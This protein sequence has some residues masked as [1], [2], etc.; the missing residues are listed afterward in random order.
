MPVTSTLKKYYA[1]AT[2]AS[3]SGIFVLSADDAPH[4]LDVEADPSF[5]NHYNPNSPRILQVNGSILSGTMNDVLN[6]IIPDQDPYDPYTYYPYLPPSSNDRDIHYFTSAVNYSGTAYGAGGSHHLGLYDG[7]IFQV[8]LGA[9]GEGIETSFDLYKITLELG[10]F[11]GPSSDPIIVGEDTLEQ[12]Q[13]SPSRPVQGFQT[14][15]GEDVTD[16]MTALLSN[17][18]VIFPSVTLTYDPDND[19][20]DSDNLIYSHYYDAS[21]STSF[22]V[23]QESPTTYALYLESTPGDGTLYIK[24]ENYKDIIFNYLYETMPF[25]SYVADSDDNWWELA[26]LQ[27]NYEIRVETAS[28]A[29]RPLPPIDD[30]PDTFD[31]DTS[32]NYKLLKEIYLYESPYFTSVL[33]EVI[34]GSVGELSGATGTTINGDDVDVFKLSPNADKSYYISIEGSSSDMGSLLNPALLGIYDSYGN[35]LTSSSSGTLVATNSS[36]QL[37]TLAGSTL[38]DGSYHGTS[39]LDEHWVFTPNSWTPH[40]IYVGSEGSNKGTYTFTITLVDKGSINPDNGNNGNGGG[41]TP[42]VANDDVAETTSGTAVV[43][44]VLANDSDADGDTLTILGHTHSNMNEVDI[45]DSDGTITYT[46]ATDFTG[47]VTFSYAID[48]GAEVATANVTVTVTAGEATTPIVDNSESGTDFSSDTQTLGGIVVGSSVT[49]TV[50]PSHDTD[51]YAV[52]L[53]A[54]ITYRIDLEG[55]DTNKGTLSNPTFFGVFDST[56][57]SISGTEDWNGGVGKNAQVDYTPSTSGLY[58]LS[59]GSHLT[60]SYTLSIDTLANIQANNSAPTDIALSSYTITENESGATVGT[61]SATDSDS[62][63]T[64]TFSLLYD[65]SNLFEVVGSTLK[66]KS[67][68]SADNESASSHALTLQVTD[69]VGNSYS[70]TLTIY[71]ADVLEPGQTNTSESSSDF[72][73]NSST[74]GSILSGYSVTGSV[75]QSG[76][77]DWF[78]VQLTAGTQYRIDLA[79]ADS[80]QGTLANPTLYGIYNS[81]SSYQSGSWDGNSGLGFNAQESFTP[82]SSGI[83]YLA[84]GGSELGSYTL[85][86]DT[87]ANIQANNSAPTDIALSSYSVTENESGATVGTLTATDSDTGDTAT[88]SLLYD[89][90]GLFEVVGSTLKLKSGSSADSESA[91]S[92]TL[93]LQVTDSVGSSFNESVT[94]SVDDVAEAG[95]TNSSESSTDFSEN[96]S[97]QGSILVGYAVTGSVGQ[98]GDRDWFAVQLTAGTQYRVDIEGADSSQG[99][100]AN[101]TLYGIYNSASSYQSGSWDG[102]SGLGLNAQESFTPSSSGIYYLAAGGS[103]LGSYTLSVDTMANIQANNSSPTN[104]TL[105]SSSVNENSAGATVGTLSANDSDSGDYH[106]FSIVSDSSN[107]FEVSGSTLSLQAGSSTDYETATSHSITVRATDSAGA[108]Y[109][110]QLTITVNDINET[111]GGT[112]GPVEIGKLT[113]SDGQTEDYLGYA[114]AI[115]GSAAIVGAYK[116]DTVA[117]S[118]GAAYIYQLS[119][120][121]WGQ[122]AKIQASDAGYSDYFGHA[123]AIS[124]D[125]ALVGAPYADAGGTNSGAAYLFQK[126]ANSDSWSEISTLYSSTLYSYAYLGYTVEIEDETAMVG[127]IYGG[128]GGAVSVFNKGSDGVSWVETAQLTAADI[129]YGDYFSI[130]MAISGNYAIIGASRGDDLGSNSGAAYIFESTDG[131]SSWA[132]KTKLLASDGASYDYFGT[133]VSIS[134]NYAI[135]GAHYDDD[136]ATATGSAYIFTS[137]DGWDSWSQVAKL[138]ASDAE[139]YDLFGANVEIVGNYA[140][141]SAHGEDGSSD[142][143]GAAYLFERS[144]DDTTW[145]E[146]TKLQASDGSSFNDFGKS[147]GMDEE[148]FIIGAFGHDSQAKDDGAA[149]IFSMPTTTSEP[150]QT[151]NSESSSDFTADTS[152]LGSILLGSSVTGTIDQAG[153][154]DWFAVQLTAGESCRIDLEGVDTDKGTLA[155]P[156]FYGVYTSSGSMVTGSADWNSGTER[157]ALEYFTPDSSGIYYLSAGSHLTGSYTLTISESAGDDYSATTSG[158]G[159]ITVGSSATGVIEESNDHDWFAVTLTAGTTYQI[160]LEGADTSKGSLVNPTFYGVY[161]SAGSMVTGSADWNGGVGLNAQEIFTATSSG[162]H[163]LSAGSHLTGSYTLSISETVADDYSEAASGSGSVSVGGSV[164]GEIEQ[165]YD[166]DWF[167][168]T[169]TAGTTYQI[170][171]EGSATSQG[172]LVNPTFYGVY[173][174]AGSMIT[175]SADWNGGVGLNAQ[176]IFTATS[177]GTHYLSAGSHLT[178]TYTLS[179]SEA[180]ADDYSAA[181]SGS[182]TVSVGGSVTGEIEQAYDEDW[183]AVTLSAG[184][185]YRIDLEGSDTSKGTLVNPTLHGIYDSNGSY[186]ATSADWNSGFGLN[187][188]ELYTPS[189]SGTYYLSSGSHLTGTYTLSVDTLA[190]IQANNSAPTNITLSSSSVTENEEGATVGTLSATDSDSGDTATFSILT[191]SSGLFEIEGTTLKL[192][193]GSSADYE[194]SSSYSLQ[195]QVVDSAGESYSESLTITVTD[196]DEG[197]SGGGVS[198]SEGSTDLPASTATSGVVAVNGSATGTIGSAYEHDWF[199]VQLESG[200]TYQIDLE[201]YATSKGTLFDPLLQAL[202]TSSGSAISGTYN[203]DGGYSRNSQLSYTADSSDTYYIGTRAYGSYTGSY[204]LSVTDFSSQG[205]LTALTSTI[206]GS[207]LIGS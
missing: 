130:D 57:S 196:V 72:S 53:T 162:T 90:S 170:D 132:Q 91:S 37:Q 198:V 35:A 116:E 134:G 202:Y 39:A 87:M 148:H 139:S 104:I 52:S 107:L 45:N 142:N 152:T 182:G 5:A 206:A 193:S 21:D 106:L 176:E 28:Y 158:A 169:L 96:S 131:G 115:S 9:L 14:F 85:S 84:A 94:I 119:N 100:L 76:D 109:D 186:I 125:Y 12:S 136:Q 42:P 63:D 128:T 24:L 56:G 29:Q 20:Y 114:S 38:P 141:I 188:Q 129:Q 71:V 192:Q 55:A 70:E 4:S 51:W 184:T 101:P 75:G 147:L 126:S 177:S 140:L 40:Y 146:V 93:T 167:A 92:H 205:T 31:E 44:P 23:Y 2:N 105:S 43:I 6:R 32:S 60:G 201:G 173:T 17:P 187:A 135:V 47:I 156:T 159:T 200:V 118:A 61:L 165:G 3:G 67:G 78:A 154:R 123:V 117:T 160:D 83:Y 143:Q 10:T 133:S 195:L 203:D 164:T 204:T 185:T 98:S 166:K 157:N 127:T 122:T 89:S 137:T 22:T 79:G 151:D 11:L 145:Q 183:F 34:E 180:I 49:G 65:S 66:L 207:D 150:G 120:G 82:S 15:G 68:S 74:Q 103:G 108:T 191:D 113:A 80:G 163:Y 62:G 50:N 149:Y 86:V 48:D 36:I 179:I 161:T 181:A 18:G 197:S 97:T 54:G 7:D 124:G 30:F 46:P 77:R 155:N 168:V 59:A 58:Y 27:F 16:Q 102:N 19:G 178:G 172:S 64:A 153:D 95:Q 190:N 13:L 121:S 112:T 199:A 26:A 1:S 33:T 174:S 144:A 73:E 69:S 110:K 138:T 175:G 41:G 194:S 189:S 99:T 111:S 25:Q 88:F 8:E 171:L 81:A